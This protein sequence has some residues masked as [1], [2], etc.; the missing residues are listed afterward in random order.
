MSDHKV[1]WHV[2]QLRL[3]RG[4]SMSEL[5]RR[6]G[7]SP[8]TVRQVE[9]ENDPL[10]STVVSLARALRVRVAF[11]LDLADLPLDTK[12]MTPGERIKLSRIVAGLPQNELAGWCGVG[13]PYL[14]EIE[15]DEKPISLG[16]LISLCE[17][18]DTSPDW[19]LFGSD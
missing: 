3:E 2:R 12:Q 8:A 6:S 13:A 7:L 11:L 10:V 14:S 4:W 15:S 16:L 5:A 18:L 17:H 19:I 9:A 1:G